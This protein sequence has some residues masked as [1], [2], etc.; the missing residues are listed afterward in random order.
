MDYYSK[1]KKSKRNPI[2]IKFKKDLR[3]WK[4]IIESYLIALASALQ[5]F[6]KEH[7]EYNDKNTK[8]K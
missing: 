1:L 7:K 3:T 8:S 2:R 5:Q 4:V 6:E